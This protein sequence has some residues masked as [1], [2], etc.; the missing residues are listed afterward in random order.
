MTQYY[1]QILSQR[2]S[3]G[4]AKKYINILCQRDV[5]LMG[6]SFR[7]R[8]QSKSLATHL[9]ITEQ[10]LGQKAEEGCEL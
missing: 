5:V 8:N 4:K 1:K 2:R 10:L 9:D 7:G 3:L 6:F